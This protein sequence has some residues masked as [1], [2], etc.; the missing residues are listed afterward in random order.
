M[1]DSLKMIINNMDYSV[2]KCS[3]TWKNVEKLNK[4]WSKDRKYIVTDIN[5]NKFLL[6]LSDISLYEKKKEQFEL[7][8]KVEALDINASRPVEFGVFNDTSIYMVLTYLEGEDAEQ[9]MQDKTNDEA[10]NLGIQA[11]KALYKL[12]Q[13]PVSQGNQTWYDRFKEKIEVKVKKLN[14]CPYKLNNSDILV[15]YIY[16]NMDIL[17][18]RSKSFTHGDYHLGNMIVNENGIG[19]IDFDKNGATDLID[20]FKPFCWNI[21]KSEYFETGLVNGY[22]NNNIPDN[23]WH[24]IKLYTAEHLISHLPWASTFGEKE[25]KTAYEIY[26]LVMNSYDNFNLLIPKWYKGV[27]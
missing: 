15:D 5:N 7:L 9:I 3:S 20:D 27:L 11:G 25:I 6:R 4:G 16:K 18:G 21:R 22:F 13:I 2:I 12:H 10:Y 26:E 19:I 17:K 1:V 23:F 14:E 24:L 8:K